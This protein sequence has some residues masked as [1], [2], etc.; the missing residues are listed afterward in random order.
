M[1]LFLACMLT[2]VSSDIALSS[3]TQFIGGG[4]S[5]SRSAGSKGF[6]RRRFQKR[7]SDDED[8]SP[9]DLEQLCMNY[10]DSCMTNGQEC[11]ECVSD[12]LTLLNSEIED[13]RKPDVQ[14]LYDGCREALSQVP[15]EQVDSFRTLLFAAPLLSI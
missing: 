14:A 5:S 2:R 11:H 13:D 4:I 8:E 7:F 1:L 6:K 9:E 12:C 3:S 15:E 10:Y